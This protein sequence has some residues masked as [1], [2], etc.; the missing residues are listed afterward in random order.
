LYLD[1]EA[2]IIDEL[3]EHEGDGSELADE[4]RFGLDLKSYHFL[5][6]VVQLQ[7]LLKIKKASEMGLEPTT[8]RLEV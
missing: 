1:V 4:G 2:L 3:V 7:L 5:L 8:L 6:L